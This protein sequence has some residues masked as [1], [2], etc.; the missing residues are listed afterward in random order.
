MNRQVSNNQF[1]ATNS[2]AGLAVGDTGDFLRL[3]R[4]PTMFTIYGRIASSPLM[5]APYHTE[6]LSH[7]STCPITE[8][9]GATK[10]F[11]ASFGLL[12]NKL[13]T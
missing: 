9:D 8:A 12:S 11:G 10:A 13:I 4:L 6:D 7:N 3:R 5:T 2:T 1:A